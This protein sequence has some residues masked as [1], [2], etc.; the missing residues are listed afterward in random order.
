MNTV[1]ALA[2]TVV[3]PV[4]VALATGESTLPVSARLVAA[5]VAVLALAVAARGV[6]AL[7]AGADQ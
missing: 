1:S 3:A 2:L 7:T 6:P 5:V 4:S